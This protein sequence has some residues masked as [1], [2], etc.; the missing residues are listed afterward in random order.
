L[1]LFNYKC[2]S[3]SGYTQEG[4]G[5]TELE[6]GSL[7]QTNDLLN[8]IAETITKAGVPW[9]PFNI[10]L[11]VVKAHPELKLISIEELQKIFKTIFK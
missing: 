3:R 7:E 8:E 11:T 6:L 9:D 1:T 4:Q 2:D 5:T 10:K